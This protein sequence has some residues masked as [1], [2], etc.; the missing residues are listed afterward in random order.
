MRDT[1]HQTAITEE[2]VGLV[3]DD[4]VTGTVELCGENFLSQ[5][6]TNRVTNTLT[7]RASGGFYTGGITVFRVTRGL[8]VQL[9]EVFNLFNG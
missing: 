3:I 2:G 1:F 9:A 5:R 6:H 4:I 7:Q 8:G